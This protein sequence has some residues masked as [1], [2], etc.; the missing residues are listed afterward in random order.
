MMYSI[1]RSPTSRG[2]RGDKDCSRDNERQGFAFMANIFQPTN[3]TVH[4][5]APPFLISP[6]F[7]LMWTNAASHLWSNLLNSIRNLSVPVISFHI[8]PQT[9]M[10]HKPYIF[11]HNKTKRDRFKG[12]RFCWLKIGV[13]MLKLYWTWPFGNSYSAY[14]WLE[15]YR[16]IEYG[17]ILMNT[18]IK[19]QSHP[20]GAYSAAPLLS[21]MK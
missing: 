20:T 3:S 16:L 9:F 5:S 4:L 13:G 15:I 18:N 6:L 17:C 2:R 12:W 11:F 7:V 14:D 8:R 21:H 19:S 10:S 1:H